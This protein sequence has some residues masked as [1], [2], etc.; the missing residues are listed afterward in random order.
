MTSEPPFALV[1][2]KRA[3]EQAQLLFQAVRNSIVEILPLTADIRHVGAT[4][5]EG[6]LTKGDVDI[7]VRVSAN[8]FSDA[9]AALA[10]RFSRNSGS[11]RTD[12][13]SA[14]EDASCHPHAGIQLTIIDGPYDVFHRFVELLKN[15]PQLLQEYNS[16]KRSYEGADMAVYRAAKDAFIERALASQH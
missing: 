11:T 9:D 4:A 3:R 13:F 15:S 8:H 7:V 6:C 14:F 16:L 5:V 10:S 1:D 2:T 12:T